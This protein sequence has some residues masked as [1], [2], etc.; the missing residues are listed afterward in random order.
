MLSLFEVGLFKYFEQFF[1]GKHTGLGEAV[2]ALLNSD[3][4]PTVVL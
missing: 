2:H 3:I 4:Y 1:V